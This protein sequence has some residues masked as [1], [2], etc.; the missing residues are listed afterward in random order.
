MRDS[1]VKTKNEI[2]LFSLVAPYTGGL[3]KSGDKGFMK[4]YCPFCQPE[5]HAKYKRNFRFWINP[6]GTVCGCHKCTAKGQEKPWDCFNF[7][8]KIRGISNLDAIQELS[9]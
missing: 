6:N 7:W 9:E 2:N 8:A 4:G 3:E 1:I 5:Q